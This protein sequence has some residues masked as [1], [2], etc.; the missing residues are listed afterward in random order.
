MTTAALLFP[1]ILS[2]AVLGAHFLRDG[3]WI[4]VIGA[5][6]LMILLFVRRAW[7][8]RLI[9]AV[10]ILGALE[11]IRTLYVLV[12]VRAAHGLP[13]TR[14]AVILGVVAALS[15]ASAMLFQMPTLKKRYRLGSRR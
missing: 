3:S 13:F 4:G 12:T 7:V 11:W 10:L 2:L 1:V 15:L 6:V 9:Q 14:M 5:L 8:A